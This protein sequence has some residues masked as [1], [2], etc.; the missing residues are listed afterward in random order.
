VSA[1]EKNAAVTSA[2][3]ARPRVGER[4]FIRFILCPEMCDVARALPGPARTAGGF[5]LWGD[6]SG[7]PGV[8]GAE[9]FAVELVHW[10]DTNCVLWR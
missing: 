2:K 9:G 3:V 8:V 1:G 7:A 10:G 5:A 6:G 4:L